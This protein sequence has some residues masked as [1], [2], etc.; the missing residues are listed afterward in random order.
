MKYQ[1]HGVIIMNDVKDIII[2]GAGLAGLSALIYAK[3]AGYNV[4]VIEKDVYFG[5]QIA[6]TSV[7]D[8]YPG[9]PDIMGADLLD[10]F[11]KHA[12][13]DKSDI[14]SGEAIGFEFNDNLWNVIT[15][16]ASYK[17]RTIIYAAGARHRKLN[18]PGEKEFIGLHSTFFIWQILQKKCILFIGV[19][20]SDFQTKF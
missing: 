3:K 10:A 9:I 13:Y 4:S 20:L 19:I 1:Y 2:I 11:K 6:E 7:V 14:I 18:I 17:T 16:T 15:K 5:S 8:N 12:I